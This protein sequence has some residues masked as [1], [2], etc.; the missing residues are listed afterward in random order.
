MAYKHG[1]YSEEIPTSITPPVNIDGNSGLV[2]VI[3][4]APSHLAASAAK[5]NTPILCYYYSEAVKQLG[6]SDD[7]DKYTLME[8]VV[9]QFVL[10]G[11][12]PVVFINVLDPS[13]HYNERTVTA[14]GIKG[15]PANIGTDALIDTLEVTS[16]EDVAPTKL[17]KDTDYTLAV[18]A[19]DS[20]TKLTITSLDKVED[21]TVELSF[22]LTT[23]SDTVITAT[24]QVALN[25]VLTLSSDTNL[26]SVTVKSGGS[27]K[28]ALTADV[29]YN[30]A[31]NADDEVVITLITDTKVVDDT[32]EIKYHEVDATKV[33][34]ADIIGGIDNE[35][36]DVTG[37]ELIESVYPRLGVL[38]GIIIAPK[39]STNSAVAAVMKAK[40]RL[41]NDVFRATAIVDIDT[42]DAPSYTQVVRTKEIKNLVDPYLMVCYPKVSL[43]GKQYHLS[44]HM[45]ALMNQ[46][47]AD[48]DAIPYVSPS[49]HNLQIDSTVRKDG[50]EMWLG[51]PQANYLNG[52]GIVTAINFASGW[53]L[54]GNRTGAYP[55]NN[56]VKD[57]FIPLR[58]M[59]N[60]IENS[61]IVNF[62]SRIDNPA[63]RRLIESIVTSANIWF[64]SMVSK[65][66][67]L[68]GRVEFND[69]D[70]STTNLMDGILKFHVYI[71][72]PVPAKEIDW[73]TEYDPSYLTTLFG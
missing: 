47:D 27:E 53:K 52:N 20:D 45:A 56:D 19:D 5:P 36:G 64:A 58:R 3:G 24:A 23:D 34:A 57:N 43:D 21:D 30:A 69:V 16:G 44:T 50:S 7:F 63:N 1:I 25:T 10:Y 18:D 9:T 28:V 55:A 31:R 15:T 26:T 4:T 48:N 17:V 2:T 61:L 68:G 35:T 37:L 54:W 67:L 59:F 11:V 38:P 6:F 13:K 66:V 8:A 29:D 62:W 32:I 41:I 33:T 46:V 22:K 40:A 72:P 49:N 70:N 42:G 51:L 14:A 60:Y 12:S 65:G 39:Y 73:L 71:T